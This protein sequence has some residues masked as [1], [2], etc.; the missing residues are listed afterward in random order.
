M[1]FRVLRHALARE[2]ANQAERTLKALQR[3]ILLRY[4]IVPVAA[5]ARAHSFSGEL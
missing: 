4:G 2:R 1:S 3:G 5:H